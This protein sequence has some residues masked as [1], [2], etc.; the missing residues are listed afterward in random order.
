MKI[1]NHSKK[2]L[3]II[4]IPCLLSCGAPAR[5]QISP[6]SHHLT[7]SQATDVD[8]G[9]QKMQLVGIDG[10]QHSGTLLGWTDAGFIWENGNGTDTLEYDDA[11]NYM[12][13]DAGKTY[14]REGAL[15]G[16]GADAL[17]VYALWRLKGQEEKNQED[18][19]PIA[20]ASPIIIIYALAFY[21]VLF[22]FPLIGGEM[23][24]KKIKYDKYYFNPE[25]FKSH[26]YFYKPGDVI[27]KSEKDLP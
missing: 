1:I 25:D 21:T 15:A 13:L 3:A 4:L 27:N 5:K 19:P 11:Q 17:F 9:R 10:T 23:G 8:W 22:G 12:L 14:Y 2:Y 16:L 26:P 20:D 18:P 6:Q 24:G 7:A